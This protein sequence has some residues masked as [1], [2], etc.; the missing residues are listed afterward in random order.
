MIKTIKNAVNKNAWLFLAAAWVYTLS[1]IFTNYFSYSSSPQKVA[2]ILS[3]YIHGQ[4]KSFKNLVNDSASVNA[5][6]SDGPSL[7]KEQLISDAQGIF[8]YQVNDLGNSVELFWNTNKMS[9]AADDLLNPDGNYLVNYEN[10][11]FELVKK[12]FTKN[13]VKYFFVT[14]IPV[15]WQYFMNNEYLS[16]HFA[17]TEAITDNYEISLANEGAPVIN[18]NRDTLFSIKETSRS[19]SDTPVG[20]SVFLRIV[21]LLCLL[22]FFSRV[23]SAVVNEKKFRSGF[24]LLVASFLILRLIVFL[25]P[26]PFNYRDNSPLFDPK[27][28]YGGAIN[29]SLGDLFINSLLGLWILLF[30]RRSANSYIV[31]LFKKRRILYSFAGYAALIIIPLISFYVT[32]VISGLVLRSKISFNAADFFSLTG[33]SITGFIIICILLYMWIYLTG[34]FVQLINATQISFFWQIILMMIASLLLIS[35]HIFLADSIVLLVIVV[36]LVFVVSFIK[37]RDNPSAGSL[38]SSAYFIFWSILVTALASLL[39]TYQYNIKEKESR[40]QKAKEMQE[41]A[42]STGTYLVRMAVNNFS[43]EFLKNN[44]Y[45]FNNPE[46]NIIIKD[47]LIA[48]NLGAYLNKYTT[49]IYVFDSSNTGLYNVDS[50]SYDVINSV[51]VNKCKAATMPGL[52]FY[53]NR[54]GNYNYIYSKKVM[55]DG[56]YRGSVFVLIQPRVYEN[57]ALVPELFKQD[58][59]ILSAGSGYMFGTYDNRKLVSS[60]GWFNFSDSVSV[61]QIPKTGYYFRDSLSYNQLWYNAGNNKLFIIAKKNDGFSNFITLFSYLFVLFIV[62]AFTVRQGRRVLD[63][64]NTK[65][66]FRNIFRVNIRS[67]IQATIIGVSILSFLIIGIATISFFIFRFGKNTTTQLINNS[68]IISSEIEQALASEIIPA[69]IADIANTDS[70]N[71]FQ[72]KITGIATMHNVDINFYATSGDLLATSQPY[73]YTRGVISS[74]MDPKAYY[75]LRYNKGTRFVNTEKIGNFS[76]QS[77]YTPVKDDRDETVAYLNIPSLSAENELHDEISGF[78]VT[79][80]ILNALSFIFAGAI[81][82]ALTG[83][84]TSSLE[85]IGGKMKQIKIGSSNEEIQWSRNDEIGMLVTEY[86]KM[87]KQLERSAETLA[88]SEREGAWREMARQVAHEIK[89]PLTPMKLSLQYLQRS[90]EEN[91]PNAVELSKKLASTLVEQIDQL[92]KIA[93]DFSQFANIQNTTPE[94][95][96]INELISSLVNLYKTDEHLSIVYAPT[97]SHTE[98]FLDKAQVNRLFT[99]LI[100][101]AIEA[102]DESKI[103]EIKIGS[104]VGRYHITVSVSD[105]GS[106]I[107]QSLQ[108]KI[109]NPNFTTK[110]SGTGLGLAIC[111]AI[112]ENAAGEIWFTTAVGKGSTFYVK[113]PLVPTGS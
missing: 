34:F 76:F 39:I 4:E 48:N 3:E 85:L 87:V 65:F 112:I 33:F 99:N 102:S 79:L 92:S 42:D 23:A 68:Q 29:C 54:P 30:F 37:R 67:Q 83:R 71:S 96:D 58:N 13:D 101:N 52:Y 108:S 56:E 77:I 82:V 104:F 6:I 41:Q 1:F 45:R 40:L 2:N 31:N 72:K 38:V 81:A 98:V 103:A 43:D 53:R 28:Y 62:L 15:R 91:T 93:G 105:N 32:D 109:F 24:M 20:F 18:S 86:N 66:S 84:I 35:L 106:G 16:S 94:R 88:K 74:H 60:I 19:Y 51:I 25:L 8:A 46:A 21:A 110:S 59:D 63:N 10:G 26:F 90:M 100:K 7:I 113:L 107:P 12:S 9:P 78:L 80:I 64:K 69:D 75:E 14:L 11:V 50:T 49:R 57:T 70:E 55:N 111:N 44:F 22:T 36:L 47:S 17:V 61:N 95:F 5:I 97:N 73:L 27:I 89:N